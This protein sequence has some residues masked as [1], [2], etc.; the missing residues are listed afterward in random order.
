MAVD[1][2][3]V[4]FGGPDQATTGAVASAPYGTTLPTDATSALDNAFVD[5]G[6]CGPDGLTLS[7]DYSTA[8]ITDW[9]GSLVRKVLDTFTGEISYVELETGEVSLKRLFGED[10]VTKTAATTT[11]GTQL[12]LSIGAHMPAEQSFVFNMKDG[13]NRIRIV[14]PRGVVSNYDD[15]QFTHSDAISWGVTISCL[16]DGSGNS[17]YVYTDDGVKA[18]A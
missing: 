5:G 15:V 2:T 9:S 3:K 7:Q 13:D 14:V 18:S 17:I 1:A 4:L 8:D 11:K 6:Y 12:A 10:Y 16:D